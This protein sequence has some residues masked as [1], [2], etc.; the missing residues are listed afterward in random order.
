VDHVRNQ[1]LGFPW[2]PARLGAAVLPGC[3]RVK[4][5]GSAG[6]AP[7]RGCVRLPVRVSTIVLLGLGLA[8][9]AV[10]VWVEDRAAVAAPL[11]IIGALVVVA[12]V[13]FEAWADLEELSISQAGVTLRRRPPP[14]A[15][16]LAE[17]GLPPEVAKR[18][19]EWFDS[20][21]GSCRRSTGA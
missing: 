17:A 2:L 16:E 8:M 3:C 7:N 15:E 11:V 10:G 13:I 20:L 1:A 9:L 6:P 5:G 12:G 18:M 14:S 21:L 19:S 4:D